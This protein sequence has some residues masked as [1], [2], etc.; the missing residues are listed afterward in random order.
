MRLS[1]PVERAVEEDS[2]S[3]STS[4]SLTSA[5]LPCCVWLVGPAPI[6]YRERLRALGPTN[7]TQHGKQAEVSEAEV[8]VLTE[9]SSTARSTGRLSLIKKH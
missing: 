9:S 1:R 5:C 6:A 4:A 8:E 7:H 2:V 3:T